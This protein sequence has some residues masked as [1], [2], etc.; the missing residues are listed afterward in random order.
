MWPPRWLASELQGPTD[1]SIAYVCSF[2]DIYGC[3]LFK[4]RC[5]AVWLWM[6]LHARHPKPQWRAA[7]E[8]VAAL[9][10]Q[11]VADEAEVLMEEEED[12]GEEGSEPGDSRS[13][14]EGAP[15][16]RAPANLAGAAARRIGAGGR[17]SSLGNGSLRTHLESGGGRRRRDVGHME[18]AED[19]A[20]E[21]SSPPEYNPEV[22]GRELP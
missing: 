19:R 11:I 17:A 21:V 5:A 7:G 1:Q 2:G 18:H 16:T 12:E 14:E 13:P 9:R 3:Q 20:R 6:L 4:R 10:A 22:C 15:S 8:A